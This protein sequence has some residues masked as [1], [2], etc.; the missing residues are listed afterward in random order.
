M[1]T[2]FRLVPFSTTWVH[3]NPPNGGSNWGFKTWQCAKIFSWFALKLTGQ[4]LCE[5]IGGHSL[6]ICGL[7]LFVIA[8]WEGAWCGDPQTAC[9]NR[10]PSFI[11]GEMKIYSQNLFI[12]FN[13]I[14]LQVEFV[15]SADNWRASHYFPWSTLMTVRDLDCGA[16]PLENFDNAMALN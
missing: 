13:A 7:F 9:R 5:H 15:M 4:K 1:G 10:Q 8:R 16:H 11:S 3:P 12:L 14:R 6:T 2:R